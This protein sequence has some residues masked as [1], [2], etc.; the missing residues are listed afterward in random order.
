[1]RP[2]ELSTDDSGSEAFVIHALD[3]LEQGE[4]YQPDAG[5]IMR[6]GGLY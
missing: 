4:G 5:N 6:P 1:M 3:W 2:A